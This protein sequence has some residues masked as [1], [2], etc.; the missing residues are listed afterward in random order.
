MISLQLFCVKTD[1]VF[2]KFP[3]IPPVERERVSELGAVGQ[4][5]TNEFGHVAP[6][7]HT[8]WVAAAFAPRIALVITMN[9]IVGTLS[10]NSA[11]L[12]PSASFAMGFCS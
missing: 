4:K 2:C 6:I 5:Q 8:E 1:V 9:N 11:L 10:V 7:V 3:E 12:Q